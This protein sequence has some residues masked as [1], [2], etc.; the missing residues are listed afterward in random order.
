MTTQPLGPDGI[1]WGECPD[2]HVFLIGGK[3]LDVGQASLQRED[4]PNGETEHGESDD[5][6]QDS[7][8]PGADTQDRSN[9]EAPSVGKEGPANRTGLTGLTDLAIARRFAKEHG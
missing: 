1:P 3:T 9:V 7:T 2:A 4:Q 5:T 6:A 8:S